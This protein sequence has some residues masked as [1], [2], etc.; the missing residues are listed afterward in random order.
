M[1]GIHTELTS[2]LEISRR[3]F[4]QWH[5]VEKRQILEVKAKMDELTRVLK[6][7]GYDYNFVADTQARNGFDSSHAPTVPSSSVLEYP[8]TLNPT[9]RVSTTSH[10]M[11]TGVTVWPQQH[12]T[13]FTSIHPPLVRLP[14]QTG[15]TQ[16][17]QM[18]GSNIWYPNYPTAS[19]NAPTASVPLPNTAHGKDRHLA[20][21]M[22]GTELSYM[23]PQTQSASASGSNFPDY[24]YEAH[25]GYQNRYAPPPSSLGNHQLQHR[26][27]DVSETQGVQSRGPPWTVDQWSGCQY[28]SA[29][30]YRQTGT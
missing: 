19:T 28:E 20:P 15:N 10:P 21:S 16:H 1:P 30:S 14:E 7:A 18:D 12:A 13:P 4:F 25:N 11:E 9:K 2:R 5:L 17:Q 6:L 24:T 26:P 22:A 29:S 27:A 23:A 3:Q 8:H